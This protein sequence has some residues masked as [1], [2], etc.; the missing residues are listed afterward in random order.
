MPDLS[1][2]R[3]ESLSRSV[4]KR[5]NVAPPAPTSIR[6][7]KRTASNGTEAVG[8]TRLTV[9]PTLSQ[10]TCRRAE[11]AIPFQLQRTASAAAHDRRSEEP[12]PTCR[13]T[14]ARDLLDPATLTP[15]SEAV[16]FWR[17][18]A[19]SMPGRTT[20]AGRRR[21][22]LRRSTWARD[23]RRRTWPGLACSRP[24]HRSRISSFRMLLSLQ[25]E[26]PRCWRDTP[27]AQLVYASATA[28]TRALPKA[29]RAAPAV[30]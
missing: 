4:V 10:G 1:G 16:P 13:F 6:R 28:G 3:L 25:R 22:T 14:P 5:M 24:Q 9:P 17:Q 15:R 19:A 26:P 12:S 7:S 30:P 23:R 8:I 21:W 27:A 2:A 11:L 20:S 29:H 18:N